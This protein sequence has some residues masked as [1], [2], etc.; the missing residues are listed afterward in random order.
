[1]GSNKFSRPKIEDKNLVFR[2]SL[3][4]IKPMKEGEIITEHN[5]KR[6]RPGY[7]I[8]PKHYKDVIGKKVLKDIKKGE[9]VSW[10]KI[11]I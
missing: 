2:R 1:M 6:I 5:I 10:D 8:N 4:F 3:Y 7:G 11:N 9:R